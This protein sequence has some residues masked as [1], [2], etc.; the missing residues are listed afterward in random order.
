MEIPATRREAKYVSFATMKIQILK[1]CLATL[2]LV[3]GLNKA[4]AAVDPTAQASVGTSSSH[5]TPQV[6]CCT[7]R[8]G[9]VWR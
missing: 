6:P 5:I 3:C 8:P 2:L 1:A 9:T 4:S 7:I